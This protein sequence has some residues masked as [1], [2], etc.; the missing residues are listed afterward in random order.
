MLIE[1][2]HELEYEYECE[3]ALFP[4][5]V[6]VVVLVFDRT[7]RFYRARAVCLRRICFS[8]DIREKI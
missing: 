5:I 7:F 3:T 1:D 8:K 2:E 4:N 6:L